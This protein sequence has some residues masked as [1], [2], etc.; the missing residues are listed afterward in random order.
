MICRTIVATRSIACSS[1]KLGMN[2]RNA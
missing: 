2:R 1:R